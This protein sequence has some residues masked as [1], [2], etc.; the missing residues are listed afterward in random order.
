MHDQG[1]QERA[2]ISKLFDNTD[3]LKSRFQEQQSKAEELSLGGYYRLDYDRLED[4]EQL[5][6]QI[7]TL[8]KKECLRFGTIENAAIHL[9][10]YP[11]L[12]RSVEIGKYNRYIAIKK[13][14]EEKVLQTEGQNGGKKMVYFSR[15]DIQIIVGVIREQG[16]YID[17]ISF[18]HVNA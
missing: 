11:M 8:A 18:S 13:F 5:V 12:R 3:A 4:P 15:D 1:L 2:A 6:E 7:K 10:T 17:T 16:A 9:D 14:N